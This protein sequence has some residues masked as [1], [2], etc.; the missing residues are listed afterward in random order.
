[1]ACLAAGRPAAA[2]KTRSRLAAAGAERIIIKNCRTD[3]RTAPLPSP[4][5]SFLF[6]LWGL[7]RTS[8]RASGGGLSVCSLSFY[9]GHT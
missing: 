4:S 3:G 6:P 7:G 1:M 5:L 9:P 2:A 8:E